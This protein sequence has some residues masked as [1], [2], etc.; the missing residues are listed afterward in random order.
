MVCDHFH[1]EPIRC[2]TC[3][4]RFWKWAQMHTRGRQHGKCVG[5]PEGGQ[6]ISFYVCAARGRTW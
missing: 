2:P 4:R 3:I 6:S 1:N 5:D